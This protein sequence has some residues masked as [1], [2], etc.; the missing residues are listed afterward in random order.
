MPLFLNT[1]MPDA[2]VPMIPP[3]RI[4]VEILNLQIPHYPT[5]EGWNDRLLFAGFEAAKKGLVGEEASVEDFMAR[6]AG[7][8][9][10]PLVVA[11]MSKFFVLNRMQP[12]A[13]DL[14]MLALLVEETSRRLKANDDHAVA[15]RLEL[16]D[17]GVVKPT[18]DDIVPEAVRAVW[19]NPVP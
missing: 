11:Q 7:E 16:I 19:I 17:D 15:R 12:R 6:I 14:F 4:M 2:N 1:Q 13:G 10:T 5:L 9:G 8:D 3:D 18:G